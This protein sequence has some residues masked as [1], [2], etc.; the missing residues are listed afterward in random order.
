MMGSYSEK[1]EAL[2]YIGQP[3][4][5]LQG[6]I[7]GPCTRPLVHPFAAVAT[8]WQI[9]GGRHACRHARRAG[10]GYS[11]G[12]RALA[13][14]HLTR[15]ARWGGR[16]VKRRQGSPAPMNARASAGRNP[17]KI[18]ESG[19]PPAP[20]IRSTAVV[21]PTPGAHHRT[22]GMGA[23]PGTGTSPHASSIRRRG[24]GGDGASQRAWLDGGGGRARSRGMDG[25]RA[26]SMETWGRS[27]LRWLPR[28]KLPRGFRDPQVQ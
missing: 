22:A 5:C 25:R 7:Y 8:S 24:P 28:L 18:P 16:V 6:S 11:L 2:S 20:C 26:L 19:P 27:R 13:W 14:Q 12:L 21:E 10:R 4:T 3:N 17:G 23:L 9:P 15:V 1:Y